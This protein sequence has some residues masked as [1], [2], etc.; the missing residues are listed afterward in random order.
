MSKSPNELH[1]PILAEL[2]Q[3]REKLARE[4]AGDL[5]AYTEQARREQNTL[6]KA[7]RRVIRKRKPALTHV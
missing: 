6:E 3:T 7:G 2:H 4:C 5:M 1:D